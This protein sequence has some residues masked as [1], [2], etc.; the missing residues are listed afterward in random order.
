[1]SNLSNIQAVAGTLRRSGD[2]RRAVTEG[3]AESAL[4]GPLLT[5]VRYPEVLVA[6]AFSRGDDLE[7]VLHPGGTPGPQRL[8][9]ERLKPGASY[10][11]R[12]AGE[13]RFVADASGRARFDVPLVGRTALEIA[14]A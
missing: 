12:G 9:L 6:R 5:E 1:M 13:T 2:F 10:R 11:V 7:L 8:G 3:P 14:P 4:R